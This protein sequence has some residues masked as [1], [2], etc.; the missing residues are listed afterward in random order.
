MTASRAWAV[1]TAVSRFGAIAVGVLVLAIPAHVALAET[2]PGASAPSWVDLITQAPIAAA[3]AYALFLNAQRER[4]R[5]QVR[6]ELEKMQLEASER[7]DS[8][9][10]GL[11]IEIGKLAVNQGTLASAVQGLDRTL[12]RCGMRTDRVA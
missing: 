9:V 11:Q 6:V 1:T 3:L 4:E 12:A 8:V 7:R 10:Q 5:D 2:L